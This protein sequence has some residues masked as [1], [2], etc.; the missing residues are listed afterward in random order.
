MQKHGIENSKQG[1]LQIALNKDLYKNS[2]KRN[3]KNLTEL[4]KIHQYLIHNT[5]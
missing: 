2:S 4:A 3:K 1:I 5:K